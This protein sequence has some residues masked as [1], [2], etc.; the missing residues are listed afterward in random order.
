MKVYIGKYKSWVGQATFCINKP[1]QEE[2]NNGNSYTPY[3]TSS[4]GRN[5]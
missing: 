5:Q 3:Y 4:Y 1:I 2:I